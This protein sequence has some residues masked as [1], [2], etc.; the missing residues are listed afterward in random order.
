MVDIEEFGIC[1]FRL[2]RKVMTSGKCQCNPDKK[3][4]CQEWIEK[5]SC[6]CGVFWEKKTELSKSEVKIIKEIKK[7]LDEMLLL[8]NKK[9]LSVNGN[10][11][12]HG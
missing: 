12:M 4:P 7:K 9:S 3:C 1:N 6:K 10:T 11:D 5:S 8:N 2:A